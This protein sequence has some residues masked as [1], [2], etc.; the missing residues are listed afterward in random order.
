M[1]SVLA[2][3]S[4]E[5]NVNPRMLA[6]GI[7]GA[8]LTTAFGLAIAMPTWIFYNFFRTRI[9][10]LIIE[11]EKISLRLVAILKRK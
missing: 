10:S 11:M 3:L 2:T 1:I 9:Q 5:A 8:L 6:G 4:N 7:S